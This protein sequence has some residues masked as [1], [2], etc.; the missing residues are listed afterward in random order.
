MSGKPAS[1]RAWGGGPASERN[2]DGPESDSP[3]EKR[4]GGACARCG[5]APVF[6][7]CAGCGAML[8]GKCVLFELIGS[9]CG[10]VWPLWY[11][12]TCAADPLVN[13]NA[14]LRDSW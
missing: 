4:Q 5:G 8:C 14:S 7:A 10:C 13:P 1:P 3:E 2:M 6:T 12:P 11:C 9:G